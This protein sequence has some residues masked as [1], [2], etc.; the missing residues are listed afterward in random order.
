MRAPE[1]L[2][3]GGGP[4]GSLHDV[5]DAVSSIMRGELALARAETRKALRKLNVAAGLLV[6]GF[7][8]LLVAMNLLATAAVAGLAHFGIGPAWSV[9]WLGVGLLVVAA[10]L[11][12]SAANRARSAGQLPERSGKNLGRDIETL[13]SG[14]MADATPHAN[15]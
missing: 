8:F 9:L 4:M 6:L 13:K 14:V 11:F 12:R 7:A 5:F 15:R 2:H 1:D 10:A 3:R